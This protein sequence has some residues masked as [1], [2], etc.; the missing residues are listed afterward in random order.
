MIQIEKFAYNHAANSGE[1]LDHHTRSL[2]VLA[3]RGPTRNVLWVY[4]ILRAQRTGRRQLRESVVTRDLLRALIRDH[5][6]RDNQQFGCL[7]EDD[8]VAVF[9]G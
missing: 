1:F 3:L 5:L 2:V 4:D 6:V 8:H 7:H 9:A